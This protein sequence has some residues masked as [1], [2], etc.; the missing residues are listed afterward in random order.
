MAQI[1]GSIAVRIG[2]GTPLLL[3]V[4]NPVPT[5]FEDSSRPYLNPIT[6][7]GRPSELSRDQGHPQHS[8]DNA[9]HTRNQAQ[10]KASHHQDE[11]FDYRNAPEDWS[12][13]FPRPV[14]VQL[15]EQGSRLVVGDIAI[16]NSEFFEHLFFGARS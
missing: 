7:M 6:P 9:G 2:I 14:K 15:Q 8:Q 11:P 3:R 13:R 4:S 16:S 10:K 12:L 1:A 5:F